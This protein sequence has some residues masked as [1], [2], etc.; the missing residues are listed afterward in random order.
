MQS[1]PSHTLL[2]VALGLTAAAA[3][4]AGGLLIV[5]RD[6]SQR[7]LKYFI[8]L[9][10]GFLLATAFLEMIPES[11]NLGG[12]TALVFVLA[13]YLLVHF[14]EHTLAPHF[15]FGEETHLEEVTPEHVSYAAVL[16]LVIH[17]F[18]DGVAIG[19]GFVVSA[20]LGGVIFLAVFLH[21]L[22]EGFTAASLMLASGRSRRAALGAAAMLGA[23][24][25]VG[26]LLMNLLRTQVQQTLPLSAG[27]SI[28]VAASDLMPEVNREPGVRMA[29]VVFLGVAIML[30]LRYLLHV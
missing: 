14:F 21:K 24:T 30:A 13:G 10:A 11:L 2:A 18:F 9:G 7:Y 8:A 26:V 28:Y 5:R 22:P 23:A 25:L 19:S 1:N 3:N 15:H 29:L 4:L 27:V 16:G 20:W 17:A 6:W 12:R